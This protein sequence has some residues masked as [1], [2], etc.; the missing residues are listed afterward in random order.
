MVST[1][2][3]TCLA[4]SLFV[5]LAGRAPAEPADKDLDDAVSRALEYLYRVQDHT[6]GSW[7]VG[8]KKHTAVTALSIMAFLSAGHVPGE[9][10]YGDAVEKGVRW[11]LQQQQP[12][13][14]ILAPL[15]EANHEM[16]HH[17]ICTL[18]LAEVAGMTRGRLAEDVKRQLPRAVAVILRAQRTSGAHRGGW[19]YRVNNYDGDMSVTGWQVM[20]LRAAKNVGC[21]V[22]S[23]PIDRAVEYIERCREPY[24]GGYRY[25]PQ[26]GLTVACTGT[27]ILA[28][29][30]CGKE[31][32]RSEPVLK[33]GGFLLRNPPRWGQQHFFYSVYYCAQAMFQLGGNYWDGFR[34][35]LH[36]ALLRNQSYNGA[37]VGRDGEGSHYGPN[38]RT[39]MG[40]LALTVEY[41]LLPIYQRD[42]GPSAKGTR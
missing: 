40:V 4:L 19:R 22:A 6:D 8:Q 38:Y 7:K 39:A 33:A 24:T 20:A 18:M 27:G 17:G 26:G 28:L 1:M 29:E 37:W 42:E 12:D 25:M 23:G 35:S 15:N 32:H 2:R 9:G 3:T 11:V 14:R 34:P 36:E 10:R 31:Q 5:L 16:Y 21:D 30:V 13:G 41:R